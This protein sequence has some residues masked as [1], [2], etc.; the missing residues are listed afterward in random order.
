MG[1]VI[2]VKELIIWYGPMEPETVGTMALD[3]ELQPIGSLTAQVQGYAEAIDAMRISGMISGG[4]AFGAKL[5]L[6][7]LSKADPST[8]KSVLNIPLSLQQK[9][10]HAGPIALAK[11]PPVIW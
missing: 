1:G 7:G 11:I 8:G 10:L 3:R 5:L 4:D 2:G 9:T 6:G